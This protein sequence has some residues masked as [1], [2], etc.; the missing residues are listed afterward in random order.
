MNKLLMLMLSLVVCAYGR[1]N[2]TQATIT[3]D[4]KINTF[5][6]NIEISIRYSLPVITT[7]SIEFYLS[8]K[9]T[10]TSI[11]GRYVQRY[12]SD[13][14]SK[15]ARKVTIYFQKSQATNYEIDFIYQ[16]PLDTA[17]LKKYGY[18]ELGL[19]WFWFPVHPSFNEWKFNFDLIVRTTDDSFDL[20]SNGQIKRFSSDHYN[21]RSR[22]PDFDIDLFLF[23]DA[24]VIEKG[25][26]VKVAGD[27]NN[28]PLKDSIATTAAGYIDFY[29]TLF[30]TH[31]AHVTCI[32]RPL[33]KDPN[34]F[35][36]ARY[37]YFVLPEPRQLNEVKVYMA[38]ELAHMWFLSG[39][40][41]ENAWLT[42][43]VAEFVAMLL[44]KALEGPEM[45][46]KIVSDK[47]DRLRRI[48]SSGKLL[49]PLY[50]NGS[51]GKT[52]LTQIA[53]YHK[54]PLLLISLQKK[55]GEPKMLQLLQAITKYRVSTSEE[56]LQVLEKFTDKETSDYFFLLLKS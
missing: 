29:N 25:R 41:T 53:L 47:Q 8:D 26:V 55:I 45:F 6:H 2:N 24:N 30:Q 21:I 33:F 5:K 32:F 12:H 11:E 28:L 56:F 4:L 17:S 44:I 43:T 46:Q 23:A 38:H 40:P 36:Y 15:P 50:R 54:G 20:F 3:G 7:D 27:L 35:G 14:G 10:I 1:A 13:P 37:G 51:K 34:A 52:M 48:E 9:C 31:I 16:Y 49:P 19:D 22:I 18:V 42:E 39:E